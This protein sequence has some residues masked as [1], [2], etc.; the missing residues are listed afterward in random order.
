MGNYNTRAIKFLQSTADFPLTV[1]LGQKV[2]SWG[3]SRWRGKSDLRF[4]PPDNE[5]FS[6]RGDKQRL[7]Y[8]GRKRSHRFTILGDNSFE[9]D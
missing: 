7:I 5:S 9:Y 4:I 2:P 1:A 8:K 6:L 3:L